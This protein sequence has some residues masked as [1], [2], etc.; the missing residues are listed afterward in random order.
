MNGYFISVNLLKQ[1]LFGI[2]YGGGGAWSLCFGCFSI[3]LHWHNK[4]TG[5]FIVFYNEFTPY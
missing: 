1:C 4:K 5:D 3:E 2:A